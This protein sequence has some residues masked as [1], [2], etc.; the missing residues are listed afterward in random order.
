MDRPAHKDSRLSER[1]PTRLDATHPCRPEPAVRVGDLP[2]PAAAHEELTWFFGPALSEI[3]PGSSYGAMVAR[4]EVGGKARAHRAPRQ[5]ETA[6]DRRADALHAARRIYERLC[7]LPADERRL[8]QAVF[9]P[10]GAGDKARPEALAAMQAYEDV[11]DT[12]PSVAP[13]SQEEE[14]DE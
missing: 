13:A 11:R 1:Q 4:L 8:L 14:S 7:K 3:E 2:D 10:D 12:G 9:A 5:A 6:G